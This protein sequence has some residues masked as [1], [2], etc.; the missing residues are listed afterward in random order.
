MQLQGR[1]RCCFPNATGRRRRAQESRAAASQSSQPRSSLLLHSIP[2]SQACIQTWDLRVKI[3]EEERRIRL[4]QLRHPCQTSACLVFTWK[5]FLKSLLKI[6]IRAAMPWKGK[7]GK[8]SEVLWK[9]SHKV[10]V[11]IPKL[12]LS[13]SPT[14]IFPGKHVRLPFRRKPDSQLAGHTE[15][16]LLQ[17]LLSFIMLMSVFLPSYWKKQ[18]NKTTHSRK[19]D[20]SFQL[21]LKKQSLWIHS[22]CIQKEG[23]NT[24][25]CKRN[26]GLPLQKLISG[27]TDRIIPGNCFYFA[28]MLTPWEGSWHWKQTAPFKNQG[29]PSAGISGHS[30]PDPLRTSNAY[31]SSE[32]WGFVCCGTE[33]RG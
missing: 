11:D 14:S 23:T 9:T 1:S 6:C 10:H 12:L 15:R 26:A 20:H 3:L 31:G 2:S 24:H 27:V 32:L 13:H 29:F 28:I 16:K 4:R 7:K 5:R 21:I 33:E 25:G 18:Q 30:H 17:S 19:A 22:N 8:T